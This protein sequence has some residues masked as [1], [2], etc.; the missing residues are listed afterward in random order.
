M[1][2]TDPTGPQSVAVVGAGVSGLTAAFRSEAPVGRRAAGHAGYQHVLFTVTLL[3]TL[4]VT[5]WAGCRLRVG[6]PRSLLATGFAIC[7]APA[8]AAMQESAE[9]DDD[10]VAAAVAMVTIYG[11]RARHRRGREA[12]QGGAVGTR[13][14]RRQLP[15]AVHAALLRW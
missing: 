5:Y 1:T 8:V 15:P 3:V 12:H 7:G 6:R 4:A 2:S 13:G 11:S 10:D 9:A 14:R